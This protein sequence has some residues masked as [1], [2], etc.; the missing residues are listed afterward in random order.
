MK[1]ETPVDS[2]LERLASLYSGSELSDLFVLTLRAL[3]DQAL[4]YGTS[5]TFLK[6]NNIN[7]FWD[8]DVCSGEDSKAE[9]TL[10]FAWTVTKAKQK[11]QLY[12]QS[13]LQDWV[14]EYLW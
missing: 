1:T 10:S 4:I 6:L 14:L 2:A 3:G 8:A 9:I 5:V 13:P 11:G 7:A 12:Q